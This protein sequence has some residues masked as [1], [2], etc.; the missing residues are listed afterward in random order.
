MCRA[1]CSKR[2]K[3]GRTPSIH[4]FQFWVCLFAIRGYYRRTNTATSDNRHK[5]N[6]TFNRQTTSLQSYNLQSYSLRSSLHGHKTTEIV[7]YVS[8]HILLK[9]S[10]I[11]YKIDIKLIVAYIISLTVSSKPSGNPLALFTSVS[12]NNTATSWVFFSVALFLHYYCSFEF[13]CP[14][15][16]CL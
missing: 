13:A 2:W 4:Q 5:S 12:T 7:H 6:K 3:T 15:Y 11:R 9:S 1:S 10:I 14:A 16:S 8:R